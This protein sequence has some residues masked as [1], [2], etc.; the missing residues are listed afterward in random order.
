MLINQN[1]YGSVVKNE[2][3]QNESK[4]IFKGRVK[5]NV[6]GRILNNRFYDI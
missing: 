1:V 6:Q 5:N 4:S 3:K 2:N